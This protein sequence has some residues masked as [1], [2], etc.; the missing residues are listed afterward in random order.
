MQEI[1]REILLQGVIR[2]K[3]DHLVCLSRFIRSNR[4]KILVALTAFLLVLGFNL[5]SVAEEA[6]KEE[7]VSCSK[8]D[9]GKDCSTEG[10]TA[11][12]SHGSHGDAGHGKKAGYG[13]NYDWSHKRQEQV[14]A[15]F[16]EKQAIASKKV[17]PAKVKLESPKF[18]AKVSGDTVKLEWTASEGAKAYHVQVS[19]DA[20][21][22]NRSMYVAEDKFVSGTSFEV[23]GLEAGIKYF[24][25][26]AATNNEQEPM[27]TKSAFAFSEFEVK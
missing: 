7:A 20:G 16:P 24:W 23:K 5:K 15:I 9:A 25:R 6:H 4:M 13:A 1:F 14:A 12:A 18:L 17:V 22:N 3:L 27:F 19:K 2:I 26:V 10:H 8:E 11:D 21:F